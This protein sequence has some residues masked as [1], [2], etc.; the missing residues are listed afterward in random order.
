MHISPSK[1]VNC[2]KCNSIPMAGGRIY[3]L[4]EAAD[5]QKNFEH[6]S[7]L[8]LGRPN[9]LSDELSE[10]TI[11]TLFRPNFLKASDLLEEQANDNLRG[12]PKINC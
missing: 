11:K 9:S 5:F 7:T 10:I 1:V 3:E 6:L 12:Q 2:E 4:L 8:L